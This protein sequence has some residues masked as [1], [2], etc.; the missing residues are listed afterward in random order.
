MR[1]RTVAERPAA[2]PTSDDAPSRL[3]SA[4]LGRAIVVAL[5]A[6]VAGLELSAFARGGGSAVEVAIDAALLLALWRGHAW[7]R[8]VL[9]GLCIAVAV[10]PSPGGRWHSP[11]GIAFL[12]QGA[13]AVALCVVPGVGV[14]LAQRR[15]ARSG[16]RRVQSTS[17]LDVAGA[18]GGREDAR[19]HSPEEGN[20]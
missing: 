1:R 9:G 12:V 4:T 16:R 18:A 8:F 7:A 3:R 15:A 14:F 6:L 17:A 11:V 13:V 2:S 5:T 20:V 10:M 19:G